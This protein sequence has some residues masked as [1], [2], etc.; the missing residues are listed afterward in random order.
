M[1]NKAKDDSREKGTNAINTNVIN[2]NSSP[3]CNRISSIF[4]SIIH[5][6][7]IFFDI[8]TD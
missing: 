6:F 4:L 8:S 1:R 5:L 7:T 3:I 2:V